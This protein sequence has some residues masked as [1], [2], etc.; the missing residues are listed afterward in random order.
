MRSRIFEAEVTDDEYVLRFRRPRFLD[1]E[2]CAQLLEVQKDVL[3]TWRSM[4]DALLAFTEP[5]SGAARREDI[6]VD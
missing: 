2:A 1:D 3:R 4:L 5:R 6:E